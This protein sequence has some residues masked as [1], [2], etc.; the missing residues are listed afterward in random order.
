MV[1][2][3]R[4]PQSCRSLVRGAWDSEDHRRRYARPIEDIEI[5]KE[6]SQPEEKV[7]VV[8]T[9]VMPERVDVGE[10]TEDTVQL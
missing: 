4:V 3:V 2:Q 8:V 1:M 5:P 7:Q 10:T 6:R 9:M